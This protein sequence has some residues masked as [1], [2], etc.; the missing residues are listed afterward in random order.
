[1]CKRLILTLIIS[2]VLKGESFELNPI[3]KSAL[4]PGWGETVLDN[5]KRARF[6]STIELSLW[7]TCL[8]TYTFSYHQ[9]LQYQSFAIEHAGVDA[10][11]KN[12]KY[13]VDIGNYIDMEHHNSEHLRWRYIDELYSETDAWNWDTRNNMKK[14]ESMRIKSDM[15]AKTG[16]YIIGGIVMNH[17]LSAIDSLYLIRLNKV[18]NMTIIPMFDKDSYGLVLKLRF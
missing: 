8:A 1:M 12:H 10:R 9:M 3:L 7:T 2:G 11:D 13:W 16:E 18:D 5:N 4:I 6:F 15:L 17:I 14:F